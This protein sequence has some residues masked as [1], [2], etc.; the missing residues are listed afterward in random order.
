MTPEEYA[1]LPE[2]LELREV[3]VRVRQPGFRT[4]S[5]LV[6]TTLLDAEQYAAEEI[7][8]GRWGAAGKHPPHQPRTDF[9]PVP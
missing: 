5:L 7:A 2:E 3:R 6:V 4:R 8:A 9:H 1:A